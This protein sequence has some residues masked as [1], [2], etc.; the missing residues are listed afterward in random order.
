MGSSMGMMNSM[1]LNMGH[2]GMMQQQQMGMGMPRGGMWSMGR[3]MG[4]MGGALNRKP[5]LHRNI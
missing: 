2:H 4:M 1:Q 3:G 5:G